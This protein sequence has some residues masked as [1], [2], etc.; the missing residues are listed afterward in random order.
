L[1]KEGFQ[2]ITSN[3]LRFGCWDDGGGEWLAFLVESAIDGEPIGVQ[4]IFEDGTKK[5]SKGFDKSKLPCLWF[6]HNP[7]AE[8][9]EFNVC[10][11]IATAM[12]IMA[13]KGS[14]IS[15]IDASNLPKVVEHLWQRYPNTPIYIYADNDSAGQKAVLKCEQIAIG[16]FFPIKEG[17]DWNDVYV[18]GGASEVKLQISSNK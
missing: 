16:Y 7:D 13:V 18:E 17:H 8:P 14:A 10:E 6:G 12:S 3:Q 5:N 1:E 11:G 4:R 15:A 2:L 9:V